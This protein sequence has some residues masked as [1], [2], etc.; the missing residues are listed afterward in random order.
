MT[1]SEKATDLV[2]ESGDFNAYVGAASGLLKGLSLNPNSNLCKNFTSN[3][4]S[5]DKSQHEITCMTWVDKTEQDQI[6][7]GLRNGTFR[8][9]SVSDKKY[10]DS[11]KYLDGQATDKMV[12]IASYQDSILTAAESGKIFEDFST[13]GLLELFSNQQCKMPIIISSDINF[14]YRKNMAKE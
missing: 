9:F 3:L 2:P 5:I 4:H 11:L 8:T 14:R 12:G 13:I 7:V 1:L 10:C 6:L